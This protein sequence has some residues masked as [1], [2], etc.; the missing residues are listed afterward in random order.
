MK[1]TGVLMWN[2]TKWFDHVDMITRCQS[3]LTL[4]RFE[5]RVDMYMLSPFGS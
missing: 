3:D 4:H 5:H 1:R 2:Q